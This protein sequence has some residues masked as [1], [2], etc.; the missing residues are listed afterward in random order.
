MI[1][2]SHIVLLEIMN[3]LKIEHFLCTFPLFHI[4]MIGIFGHTF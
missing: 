4:I 1:D 2:G 3:E